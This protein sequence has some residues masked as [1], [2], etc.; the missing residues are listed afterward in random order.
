MRGVAPGRGN[1]PGPRQTGK[2]GMIDHR[3]AF[4]E[5]RQLK[6]HPGLANE[7]KGAGVDFPQRF[8]ASLRHRKR[9]SAHAAH[10]CHRRPDRNARLLPAPNGVH[11]EP[12]DRSR[13]GH[14]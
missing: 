11:L 1:A 2:H 8:R 6:N 13:K 7:S 10:P 9:K 14:M 3:A 5:K 12:A 4:G